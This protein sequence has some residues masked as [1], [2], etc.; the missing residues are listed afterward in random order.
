LE[1][2]YIRRKSMISTNAQPRAKDTAYQANAGP[3]CH[4]KKNPRGGEWLNATGAGW[5][6]L[7]KELCCWNCEGI[8]HW[9]TK[10]PSPAREK[11]G[12]GDGTSKVTE[13]ANALDD[14]KVT[15]SWMA[16]VLDNSEEDG[17]NEL[18]V[19]VNMAAVASMLV[20]E[21][22][23]SVDLY[24]S[25]M[26]WHI[27][28]D[29]ERFISLESI[30][31]KGITGIGWGKFYV[32]AQG[33]MIVNVPNGQQTSKMQLT[34]VLYAPEAALMLISIGRI[35]DAGYHTAF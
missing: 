24:D 12:R 25:G 6:K 19:N 31:P 20:T 26:T 17:G 34:N 35:N 10:C 21:D 13:A 9:K 1:Q 32:I 18:T 8:G 5:T 28:P 14:H 22:S 27:S 2:E 16:V 11:S 7:K 33:D 29:R 15:R 3:S 30:K 4:G 23:G